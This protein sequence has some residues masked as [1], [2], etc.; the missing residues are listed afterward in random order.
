[1]CF[2]WVIC[3]CTIISFR[4][5]HRSRFD[6]ANVLF[7][8]ANHGSRFDLQIVCFFFLVNHGSRFKLSVKS[9]DLGVRTA[10]FGIIGHQMHN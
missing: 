10:S 3:T 5:N 2:F 4:Y 7:C 8:L 6:F 9:G 1:V